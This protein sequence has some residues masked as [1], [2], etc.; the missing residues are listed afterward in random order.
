ML[1]EV[2]IERKK[3]ERLSGERRKKKR[4]RKKKSIYCKDF[5]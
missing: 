3:N 4:E 1:F 5:V 2:S